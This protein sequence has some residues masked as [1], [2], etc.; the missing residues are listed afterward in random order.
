MFSNKGGRENSV[1]GKGIIINNKNK[2]HS[3]HPYLALIVLTI[4]SS[5]EELQICYFQDNSAGQSW[6][7]QLSCRFLKLLSMRIGFQ[8]S[9]TAELHCMQLAPR[10][11]G[12]L[13]SFERWLY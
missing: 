10:T 3:F 6:N 7:E 9:E 5:L 8:N 11:H 4:V 12:I 13:S 1:G 2:N